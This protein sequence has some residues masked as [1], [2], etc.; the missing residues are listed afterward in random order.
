MLGGNFLSLFLNW[1]TRGLTVMGGLVAIVLGWPIAQ[2]A[3]QAQQA[4]SVLYA[5]RTEKRI[6]R[7]EAAAGVEALSRAI[8]LDPMA[9]RILERSELLASTAQTPSAGLEA[10]ER[11]DWLRRSRTDLIA[12]LANAPAHG[13]DWLRLAAVQLQLAGPSRQVVALM[14]TSQQMAGGIPQA[15]PTRLRLILD[16]WPL[17]TGPEKERLKR[18]VETMWRQSSTDRRLFG[19]ATRSAADHAILTWFLRDI[20]GAPQELAK[21]IEQVNKR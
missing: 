20:P 18:H 3:W 21:I 1:L 17:L 16:C 13:I 14:F 15:W 7:K 9:S 12:G 5:L 2:A 8:A 19:Y 4:D 10:G 11:T 6:D